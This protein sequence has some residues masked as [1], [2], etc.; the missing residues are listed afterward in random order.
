MAGEPAARIDP[1]GAEEGREPRPVDLQHLARYTL[2]EPALEREVLELFSSQSGLYLE[3]L[4]TAMSDRD[5]RHA[6]HSLKGCARAVGAWR[7]AQAAERAE[8]LEGDALAEFRAARI[9]EI[10]A[11]LHE[12]KAYIASVLETR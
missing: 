6:A 1:I 10:E 9:E 12:A 11:L 4:R 5:W 3:Q 8:A 2:G 7:T